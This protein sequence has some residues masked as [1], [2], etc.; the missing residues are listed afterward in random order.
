MVYVCMYVCI[1]MYVYI[2]IY[3]HRYMHRERDVYI[4]GFRSGFLRRTR[5][6]AKILADLCFI[7]V[8]LGLARSRDSAWCTFGGA[9]PTV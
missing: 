3:I 6:L 2:Y 8:C 5:E 9:P 7:V 1:H 4:G